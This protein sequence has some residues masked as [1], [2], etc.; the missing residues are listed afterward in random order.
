MAVKPKHVAANYM[1][2]H[3]STTVHLLVP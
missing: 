3:N 2:I 1:L